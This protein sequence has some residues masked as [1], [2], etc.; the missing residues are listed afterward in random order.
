[1]EGIG[2]TGEAGEEKGRV[3]KG[4]VAFA[5]VGEHGQQFAGVLTVLFGC[6]VAGGL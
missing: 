1:M 2:N 6:H 4:Q 3:G 5:N